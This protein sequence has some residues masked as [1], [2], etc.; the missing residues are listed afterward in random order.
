[1]VVVFDIDGTLIGGEEIDWQCFDDAFNEAAGFPLTPSFFHSLEEVTARSIVHQALAGATSRVK[2]DIE[3]KT[4]RGYL[5]RLEKTIRDDPDAFP[6]MEGAA[7]L[8]RDI[9]GRGIPVAI[10][11]GNWLE[12]GVMK[13]TASGIPFE[14]IPMATSSEYYSR[15]DIIASAVEKAG[16]KLSDAIYVGDGHWDLRTCRNLGIAFIGCG[17]GIDKLREEGAA[18]LLDRLNT[19]EFLKIIERIKAGSRSIHWTPSHTDG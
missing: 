8:L 4:L 2:R 11:T 9:Q 13:L 15:A 3:A 10:A 6:P 7:S 16:G 5:D 19:D 17:A 1:M 12:S 14:S 18:Y